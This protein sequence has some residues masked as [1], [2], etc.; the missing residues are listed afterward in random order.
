MIIRF[1]EAEQIGALLIEESFGWR[2]YAQQQRRVICASKSITKDIDKV[3]SSVITLTEEHQ[4][5]KI[6]V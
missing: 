5:G 6:Y 2:D 3:I 1:L 4:P